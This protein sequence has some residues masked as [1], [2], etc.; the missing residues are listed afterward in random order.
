MNDRKK[1]IFLSEKGNRFNM[2]RIGR[3]QT[4]HPMVK[5]V[6]LTELAKKNVKSMTDSYMSPDFSAESIEE[7]VPF[8]FD[9]DNKQKYLKE[10]G[11]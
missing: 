2:V 8:R 9:I 4:M 3:E 5:E 6:S 1:F 10:T 11:R 7:E